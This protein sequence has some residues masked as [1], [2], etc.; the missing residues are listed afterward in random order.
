[1]IIKDLYLKKNFI[2]NKIEGKNKKWIMLKKI[3]KKLLKYEVVRIFV[4]YGL[5]EWL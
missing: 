2:E 5:W 3:I 1:M 4:R